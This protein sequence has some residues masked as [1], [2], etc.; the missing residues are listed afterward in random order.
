MGN[1][2]PAHAVDAAKQQDQG[3]ILAD[4]V[5]EYV[6]DAV[7]YSLPAMRE[8]ERN[9]YK[10]TYGWEGDTLILRGDVEDLINDVLYGGESNEWTTE[11]LTALGF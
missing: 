1:I 8:Q 3:E 9:W 6:L 2:Y 10:S 5:F 7:G 11:H 4:H